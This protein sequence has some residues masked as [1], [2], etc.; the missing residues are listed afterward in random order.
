MVKQ[1]SVW[2]CQECGSRQSKWSGSCSACQQWN[3]INE[4]FEVDQK[5]VRFESATVKSARPLR[6][7]E[8]NPDQQ[9][10]I[11][12]NFPEFDRLMGGG[13]VPGSLTLIGGDPGV[14]KSTLL[15]QISHALALQGLI[16]LY[17]CGEESV[18]QT[19]LR[20]SRLG[21]GSESL[22][23]LN[24]TLFSQIKRHI[25]ELKPDVLIIDSVQIVYKGELASAP[26]SV[27]QVREVAT[28]CMHVAKGM[29]ISTF[30]IGHVT[31]SGE[32][33]GP[34]V[35]EHIV[36]TVLDFEGDREQGH[37]IVRA[38]KNRFGPT[39]DIVLFQMESKG[40]IEVSNP[41]VVF[42]EER[43]KE[44]PGSVI[45]PTLE[46]SRAVLVEIQALVS[47]SA[48]ST[49]SRRCSG[50]NQNRLALMLAVLE[51]RVGMHLHRCDVFVS[52]AGG[53]KIS[54]PASDL[55]MVLA[56]SSSFS[57]KPI[58]SQTVAF[59]EVGL[60]GEVRSVPRIGNRI[61]EAIHMGFKRCILP[62]RSLKGLSKDHKEKMTLVGVDFVDEA[63][64][65]LIG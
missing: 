9:K 39:D 17:V 25:D 18:E 21:V 43:T 56:I 46:G 33:A 36:D 60:G 53:L 8:V 50:L 1:K 12:T 2:V 45:I 23:L 29:G 48:F 40:L 19:S 44:V 34:R 49:S 27:S 57:N 59:G 55:A 20:A 35:L 16:V 65:H 37:R 61:K 14:G 62:K 26:G 13:I 24:E 47:A 52:A 30:L 54:E 10:R 5:Q 51:K 42:L 58:D 3:T 4:E 32:I 31:K 63:I 11:Q 41:S 15:L 28:E 22:Y 6:V 7:R 38:T 64:N